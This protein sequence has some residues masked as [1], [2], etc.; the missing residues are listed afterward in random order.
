MDRRATLVDRRP[1]RRNSVVCLPTSDV[2]FRA[3]VEAVLD[4]ASDLS[5]TDLE[6]GLAAV[7][8]NTKVRRRELSSEM[9]ET[10]YAY[11]DGSFAPPADRSWA[12]GPG[13]AW[14]RFEPLTG[15]I[16]DTNA[17]A[18]ALFVPVDGV[19]VGRFASDFVPQGTE[20]ISEQQLQAIREVTESQSAGLARRGDGTLFL[21]EFVARSRDHA[22]EAWYREL[23]IAGLESQLVTTGE[24]GTGVDGDEAA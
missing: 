23:S 16:L 24:P 11:R 13:T 14:A 15:E 2:A 9:T 1:A 6:R 19:L 8:P 12:D 7:Y 20:G 5:P 10:W 21:V 18:I 3:A 17:E 22:V 4:A